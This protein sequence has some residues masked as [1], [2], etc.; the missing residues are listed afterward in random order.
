MTTCRN[1][2]KS[3][4]IPVLEPDTAGPVCQCFARFVPSPQSPAVLS[5]FR[6]T[7]CHPD[8]LLY[9]WLTKDQMYRMMFLQR[10]LRGWMGLIVFPSCYKTSWQHFLAFN[11]IL[12]FLKNH[13]TNDVVKL[14]INEKVMVQ[15]SLFGS[16]KCV[17][18]RCFYEL[19]M[20]WLVLGWYLLN[21][22]QILRSVRAWELLLKSWT[23]RLAQDFLID[24]LN[25][26]GTGQKIMTCEEFAD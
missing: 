4:I 2:L 10:H 1:I 14:W 20:N 6:S 11:H 12:F 16:A 18:Q 24:V 13:C 3:G 21:S 26:L 19:K 25:L 5:Y 7:S 22:S 17:F 23:I 8:F 9:I 15:A